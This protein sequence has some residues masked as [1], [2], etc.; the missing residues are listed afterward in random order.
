MGHYYDKDESVCIAKDCECSR[1]RLNM[2]LTL[3]Y[4]K[5]KALFA[6]LL[7]GL[8]GCTVVHTDSGVPVFVYGRH[9]N[10]EVP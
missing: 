1:F 7:L 4:A 6:L 10:F 5:N 3:K 8:S 9:A 2:K